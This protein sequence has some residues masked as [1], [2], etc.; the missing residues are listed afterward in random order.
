MVSLRQR[1]LA[2]VALAAASS[3]ASPCRRMPRTRASAASCATPRAPACPG[4]PSRSPTRRRGATMTAVT[5][6]DGTYSF[7][8]PPGVYTVTVSL[9]GLRPAD[10][11]GP[12]GRGPPARP[13]TSR[14]SRAR[15][16]GHGHGHAARADLE[17]VPFSIAAPTEDELR[18][19]G[20]G[21]HRG[22]R[23]ERGRLHRAEPGP[24]PEPGG[25]ARRLRRPDRA[26]PA[27]REGA[28]R[29]VP[30]RLDHLP[31]A[32]HAGHRPVRRGPRGGAARAAG[33]AVRRGLALRHRALHHAT[34]PSSA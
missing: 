28:G 25:D 6:T 22:R 17:D 27:R 20:R 15:G 33:H 12:E 29:R 4:P 34:S 11:E 10:E 32:V 7:A 23:R 5:A 3:L 1:F 14:W 9:Q 30:G 18:A 13:R 26:R 16:G 21:R 31:L 8:V 2:L 24:R 19:R